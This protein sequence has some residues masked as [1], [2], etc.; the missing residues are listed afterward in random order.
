MRQKDTH[1]RACGADDHL[2]V[3]LLPLQTQTKS[4]S[5]PSFSAAC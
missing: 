4:V 1:S 2:F 5:Q 3:H